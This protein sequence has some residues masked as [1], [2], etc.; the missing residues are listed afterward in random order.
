[1]TFRKKNVYSFII[2][3]IHVTR[4]AN[5]KLF[6]FQSYE[7]YLSISSET[8]LQ[9][10]DMHLRKEDRIVNCSVTAQIKWLTTCYSA[11]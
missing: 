8:D 6:D 4:H 10:L 9:F 1:M 11:G 2:Y 5:L 7:T 3:L